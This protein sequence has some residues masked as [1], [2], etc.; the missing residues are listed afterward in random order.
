MK[1]IVMKGTELQFDIYRLN[2]VD[3]TKG[4]TKSRIRRRSDNTKGQKKKKNTNNDLQ[5]LHRKLK[6]KYHKLKTGCEI[7]YSGNVSS[8]PSNGCS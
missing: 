1:L 5:T 3:D 8:F 2:E 6:I 4:L 7:R